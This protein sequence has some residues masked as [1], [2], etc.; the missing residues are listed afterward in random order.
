ML[1]DEMNIEVDNR[2]NRIQIR[3]ISSEE[4]NEDFIIKR[5]KQRSVLEKIYNLIFLFKFCHFWEIMKFFFDDDSGIIYNMI[6]LYIITFTIKIVYF[7]TTLPNKGS[8]VQNW[9]KVGLQMKH[10][11]SFFALINWESF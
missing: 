3:R 7:K 9:H 5:T 4:Y 6:Y 10:S 1:R 2:K 11:P 8:P